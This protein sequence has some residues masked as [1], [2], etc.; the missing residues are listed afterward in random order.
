M[1][2]MENTRLIP[3]T[4]MTTMPMQVIKVKIFAK[5]LKNIA[6]LKSVPNVVYV[7]S[8]KMDVINLP[9]TSMDGW[10]VCDQLCQV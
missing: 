1:K 3:L 4:A 10:N 7:E 5:I 8:P 9:N 2:K 6:S